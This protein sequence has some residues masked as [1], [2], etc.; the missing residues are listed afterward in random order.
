MV[1]PSD[2]CRIYLK[3]SVFDFHTRWKRVRRTRGVPEGLPRWSLPTQ[4]PLLHQKPQKPSKFMKNHQKSSK[5]TQNPKNAPKRDLMLSPASKIQFWPVKCLGPRQ[6]TT[7][8]PQTIQGATTGPMVAS[9]STVRDLISVRENSKISDFGILVVRFGP[10][11][12]FLALS[13]AQSLPIGGTFR[14]LQNLP[15]NIDF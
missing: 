7:N 3:I 5:N 2:F 8:T 12:P 1:V 11:V 4:H 6:M 14:F 15:E 13:C 9:E 10:P